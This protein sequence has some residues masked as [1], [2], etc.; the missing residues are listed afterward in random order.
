MTSEGRALAHRYL[1]TTFL[2]RQVHPTLRRETDAATLR[3]ARGRRRR[4]RAGQRERSRRRGGR[5]RGALPQVCARRAH[6]G[7]P[8]AGRVPLHPGGRVALRAQPVHGLLHQ[9]LVLSAS[10]L[11]DNTEN[12]RDEAAW[13]KKKPGR[14]SVTFIALRVAN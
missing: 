1:S 9:L 3:E 10:L 6:G 5:R 14:E 12:S 2:I 13:I 8:R 4:R 11:S 7:D